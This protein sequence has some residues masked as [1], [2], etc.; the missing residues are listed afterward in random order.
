VEEA[1]RE[2]L[3]RAYKGDDATGVV[4]EHFNDSSAWVAYG[5]WGCIAHEV[6]PNAVEASWDTCVKALGGT[7]ICGDITSHGVRGIRQFFGGVQRRSVHRNFLDLTCPDSDIN[8]ASLRSFRLQFTIQDNYETYYILRP[9]AA[10]ASRTPPYVAVT[11]PIDVCTIMRRFGQFSSMDLAFEL[12]ERGIP[13]VLCPRL[14]YNDRSFKRVSQLRP[15]KYGPLGYRPQTHLPDREDWAAYIG[16]RDQF[17]RS[18]RRQSANTMTP[19]T[20]L[21]NLS[22]QRNT[23]QTKICLKL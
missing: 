14:P 2:Q 8:N 17:L 6:L 20:I 16:L 19:L 11:C 18:P 9:T 12:S 7:D 3:R 10:S 21:N 1:S 13:F 4:Q 5:R 23:S 15:Q 22:N